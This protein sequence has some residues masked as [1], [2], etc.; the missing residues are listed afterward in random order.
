VAELASEADVSILH[1]QYE[2]FHTQVLFF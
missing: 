1:I 2:Q